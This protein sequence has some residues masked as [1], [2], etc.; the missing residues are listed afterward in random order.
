MK[1]VTVKS[2][3]MADK[4]IRIEYSY[5]SEIRETISLTSNE[6]ARKQFYSAWVKVRNNI[7][8]EYRLHDR[9]FSLD[10]MKF[11]WDSKD[12]VNEYGRLLKVLHVSGFLERNGYQLMKVS[13]KVG[14]GNWGV[15]TLQNIK[16]EEYERAA[17]NAMDEFDEMISDMVREAI[18]FINGKRAQAELFEEDA[19][20]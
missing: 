11:Q 14:R 8:K 2:I 1:E 3:A 5:G 16:K 19:A 17:K 6:F 15:L 4:Y 20:K 10:S 13:M 12:L 7:K 18:N 9:N